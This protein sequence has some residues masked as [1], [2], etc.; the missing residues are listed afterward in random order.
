M[1]VVSN[2][3]I[4]TRHIY[5]VLKKL[6]TPLTRASSWKLEG[7]PGAPVSQPRGEAAAVKPSGFC[8]LRLHSGNP[9]RGSVGLSTLQMKLQLYI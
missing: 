1:F 2:S 5:S 6:T 7:L 8:S 3:I 4:F 9:P